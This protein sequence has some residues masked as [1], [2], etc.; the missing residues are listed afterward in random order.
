[1]TADTQRPDLR[2]AAELVTAV[3]RG[4]GDDQLGGPTPCP[5][6]TV[7]DLLDH[8]RGLAI[9]F[10]RAAR[11]ETSAGDSPPRV[12]AAHLPDGWRDEIPERVAELAAAWQ[13]PGAW[14]GQTAAGGLEMDGATAGLVALDELVLHGWD[15]AVASGQDFAPDR[16]SVSGARSFVAQ[17]SGPGTEGMRQGLFGPE[18]EVPDGATAFEEL[19]AMAGR[20][21]R[22]GGTVPDH[23]DGH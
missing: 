22:A 19:L 7:G 6:Y 20:D 12:D 23:P 18:R 10:T 3:V 16:A 14:T 13:D 5:D 21:P 11:K 15:L 9:A 2:P 8:L 17:F 1:M 4:V